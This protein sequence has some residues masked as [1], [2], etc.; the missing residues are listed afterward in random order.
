MLLLW[1]PP[2]AYISPLMTRE[3]T[4]REQINADL[5]VAMKDQRESEL[6]EQHT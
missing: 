2:R 5:K 4:M 6:V 1:R 3:G